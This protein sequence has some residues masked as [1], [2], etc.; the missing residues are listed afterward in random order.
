MDPIL[1]LAVIFQ[2]LMFSYQAGWNKQ[3][4]YIHIMFNLLL[5][6]LFFFLKKDPCLQ[7]QI[8]FK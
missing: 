8:L 6:C 4:Q 1:D 2:S 3:D 5:V 7:L